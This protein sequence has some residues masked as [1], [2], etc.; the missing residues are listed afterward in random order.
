MHGGEVMIELFVAYLIKYWI[1]A[2]NI[3]IDQN[4]KT[5]SPGAWREVSSN[6]DHCLM[7]KGA[8]KHEV[9]SELAIFRRKVESTCLES[10]INK[11]IT[12]I[13]VDKLSK[14]TN[15]RGKFL[16]SFVKDKKEETVQFPLWGQSVEGE[17]L[18]Y[19][20]DIRSLSTEFLDEGFQ[21]EDQCDL[22][23]GGFSRVVTVDGVKKICL[24]DS[25]CGKKNQ[26]GCFLG[27]DR[28][29]GKD[30]CIDGSKAVWCDSELKVTCSKELEYLVCE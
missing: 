4:L 27:T 17:R 28:L 23:P 1:F 10:I 29:K 3:V 22:C 13:H 15:I 21:C 30:Q 8:L 24:D 2:Q 9:Y 7:F 20:G 25:S 26:P 18:A 11:P 14:L 16:L 6:K 5:T 19:I 12:N